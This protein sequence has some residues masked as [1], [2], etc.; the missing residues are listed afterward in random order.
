[1]PDNETIRNDK[2]SKS[3]EFERYFAQFIVLCVNTLDFF[4]ILSV[5]LIDFFLACL[6]SL[7]VD[8][9]LDSL[10]DNCNETSI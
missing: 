5:S 10:T 8:S 2:E 7:L 3:I 6:L 1:M 4:D 9:T